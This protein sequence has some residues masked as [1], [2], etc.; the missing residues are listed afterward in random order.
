MFQFVFLIQCSSYNKH[1][2]HVPHCALVYSFFHR[3]LLQ[4]CISDQFDVILMDKTIGFL[5]KTRTFLSDAK[6]LNGSVHVNITSITSTNRCPRT[7]TLNQY[8]L[9]IALLLLFY[10]CSLIISYFY[11]YFLLN[12]YF[13]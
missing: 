13:S 11:F 2:E 8:P 9:Y 10:C 3:R 4:H 5:T 1:H 12:T 7:L 6:L